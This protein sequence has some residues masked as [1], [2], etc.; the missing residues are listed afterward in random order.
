MDLPKRFY[1]W[2]YLGRAEMVR[3]MAAGEKVPPE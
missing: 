1:D 2:A 3:R